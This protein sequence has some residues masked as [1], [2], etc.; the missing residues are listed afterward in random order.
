MRLMRSSLLEILGQDFIRTAHA[1]G[2]SV[3]RV[4]VGHALRNALIPVVTV[5]GMSIG[6]LLGGSIIIE[7]IFAWPGVGKL[8]IDGIASR[9][10]PL[11]QSYVLF[12]GTFFIL[13][14][15]VVDLLY[16]WL[17]PRISYIKR[18]EGQGSV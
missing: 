15:L 4:L 7:T 16:L 9:D 12:M 5:L 3:A 1:K 2:L 17:D 10:Y 6:H 11:I 18:G 8:L 13:V 14:N